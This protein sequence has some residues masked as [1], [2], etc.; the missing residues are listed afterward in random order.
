MLWKW[1]KIVKKEGKVSVIFALPF[2]CAKGAQSTICHEIKFSRNM[3]WSDRA[4][5][6]Q[7]KMEREGPQEM[8][9]FAANSV[10]F[11]VFWL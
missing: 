6:I 3:K 7:L 4:A 10:F 1:K 9:N 2:W 11:N 5:M 8:S